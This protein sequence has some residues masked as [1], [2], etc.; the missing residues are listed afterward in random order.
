[1]YLNQTL[2]IQAFVMY[3]CLCR[4]FELGIKSFHEDPC[5]IKIIEELKKIFA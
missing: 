4:W 2:V 1:M 5:Y 3:D